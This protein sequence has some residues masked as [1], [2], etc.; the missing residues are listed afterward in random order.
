[1]NLRSKA[2]A[3]FSLVE[4]MVVVAI[5]G[6]LAAV[7]IPQ[8]SKFQARARQSEAKTHLTTIYTGEMGFHQEWQHFSRDLK[9]IGA[10]AT[11]A[12]LRYDAGFVTAA[13]ADIGANATYAAMNP[14]PP[15]ECPAASPNN[16]RMSNASAGG[17]FPPTY[18]G[19]AAPG[20]VAAGPAAVYNQNTFT[21]VVWGNPNNGAAAAGG[22]DWTI[23][24]TKVMLNARNGI[25]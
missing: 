8:F 3:G 11:G 23:Q 17:E 1:M 25:N 24:E 6:I 2:Q 21:A 19:G 14:A 13:N 22:D 10:G 5:I 20:R 12:A 18:F 15:A 16:F 9:N 4:L 7:A